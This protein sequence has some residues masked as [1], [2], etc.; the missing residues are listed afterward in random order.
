MRD[1]GLLI[2][3]AGFGLT[4]VFAHGYPKLMKVINGDM[5]FMDPFGIGQAP[6]L[7]LAVITEVIFPLLI[8]IGLKTRLASI[9]VA[10]TMAAAFFVVHANDPFDI[11]EKAL[12]FLIGFVVISL[13]GSGR[14]SIDRA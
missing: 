8:V 10:I 4:M 12:L 5:A 9:P 1:L 7:I 3:R 11:K 14:Y 2:L 6:T 13:L